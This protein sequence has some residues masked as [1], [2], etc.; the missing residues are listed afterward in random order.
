MAMRANNVL[1]WIIPI[2]RKEV[3]L[4]IISTPTKGMKN[5]AGNSVLSEIDWTL[6]NM[7]SFSSGAAFG[8]FFKSL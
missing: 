2:C 4:R 8:Y 1:K 6:F 3:L 7:V 5:D